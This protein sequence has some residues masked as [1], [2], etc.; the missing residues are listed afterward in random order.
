MPTYAIGD[1]H[2]CFRTLRRLLERI[3]YNPA[4][5][6]LWLVGDLVNGGPRSLKVLRWAMAQGDRLTCV[7]GNHDLHLL[8]RAAGVRHPRRRDTLKSILSAPDREALLDWLANRPL[9]HREDPYV[10]VHAGLLPSWSIDQAQ[11][12]A[13]EIEA[14]FRSSDRRAVIAD[15]Y[16]YSDD[17]AKAWNPDLTGRLRLVVIVNAFTR[18]RCCTPRGR[19]CL[20]FSGRP[21]DAPRKCVPW[22]EVP[23]RKSKDASVIFGHWAALGLHR[24]PGVL[25]LD[26]G[27]V[28]G[29]W[30]TAVRLE[31]GEVFSVKNR[32]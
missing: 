27:C 29:R 25:A 18:L 30:L 20:A 13:A 8:A 14:Q 5:D 23:D 6:R 15:L 9:L 17:H 11:D 4:F 2:G 3:E 31:D 28:W 19:M 26:S 24:A 7:L 1:V 16:R 32:D 10:L 22:F 12:L 21:E